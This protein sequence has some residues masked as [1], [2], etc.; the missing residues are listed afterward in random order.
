MRLVIYGRPGCCLCEKAEQ[1]AAHLRREFVFTL[2]VAD[3]TDDAELL[4]RYRELIPVVTLDG[5]EIARGGLGI[6]SLRAVL[7]QAAAG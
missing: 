2:S 6:A 1:I 7:R 5:V 4:A 3:I